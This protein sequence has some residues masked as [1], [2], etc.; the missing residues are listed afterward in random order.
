MIFIEISLC[1]FYFVA[2]IQCIYTIY[3]YSY[4]APYLSRRFLRQFSYSGINIA[5][6][7]YSIRSR[8]L[9]SSLMEIYKICNSKSYLHIHIH[10]Y[11]IFYY[12]IYFLQK[13]SMCNIIDNIRAFENDTIYII[14]FLSL[15]L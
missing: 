2:Y 15:K 14:M 13:K 6:R 11:L 9:S 8:W 1:L 12:L 4:Y 10:I 5:Y 3:V 7:N